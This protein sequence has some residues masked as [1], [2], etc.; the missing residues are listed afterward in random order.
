VAGRPGWTWAARVAWAAALFLVALYLSLAGGIGGFDE[1]WFLQVLRRV[2]EGEAL[3]RD[4]WFGATPLSAYLGAGLV[5]TFGVDVVV[6]KALTAACLAGTVLLA[7]RLA[8]QAGSPRP[9]VVL[10][11][12]LLVYAARATA[13]YNAVAG[14]AFLATFTLALDGWRRRQGGSGRSHVELTMAGA[15]AGLCFMAKQNVGALAMAAVLLAAVGPAEVPLRR[16]AARMIAPVGA[17]LA[18]SFL[19]IVPVWLRGGL[20]G[21]VDYGLLRKEGYID[22]GGISYLE[23]LGQSL[24]QG[25]VVPSLYWTAPFILLPAVLV[26]LAV[27]FRGARGRERARAWVVL[28]FSAASALALF[29]RADRR[30]LYIALPAILVGAVYLWNRF[31]ANL[32]PPWVLGLRAGALAWTTTGLVALLLLPIVQVRSGEWQVSTIP[33]FGLALVRPGVQASA[34]RAAEAFATRRQG[35]TLLLSP[36]AGFYYLVTGVQNPTPYDVPLMSALGRRGEQE[37]IAAIARREIEY[38]CVDWGGLTSFGPQ[39]PERLE[40]FVRRGLTKEGRLG[41]CTLYR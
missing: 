15:A 24:G 32:R 40:R 16:R 20:P 19:L 4:V 38:V 27:A 14:V 22:I 30:H 18:T 28:V 34:L 39:R 36:K 6:L 17:F 1:G 33:R 2:S 11:V 5:W 10:A 37:V 21:L 8:V 23:G 13:A 41:F 7:L 35:R 25:A 12:A 3:Y 9:P 29:P 31:R 26:G